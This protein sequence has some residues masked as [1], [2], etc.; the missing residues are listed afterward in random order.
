MCGIV[1]GHE[2]SFG[3]DELKYSLL[4]FISDAWILVTFFIACNRTEWDLTW[5]NLGPCLII[6]CP[7]FP[8]QTPEDYDILAVTM[9]HYVDSQWGR[10]RIDGKANRAM[11]V[12]VGRMG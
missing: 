7:S 6:L 10:L 11:Y 5:L 3:Y 8:F 4:L 12:K 2:F 1:E 9:A